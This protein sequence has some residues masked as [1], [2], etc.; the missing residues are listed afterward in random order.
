[1]PNQPGDKSDA[2]VRSLG[3]ELASWRDRRGVTQ[4]ELSAMTGISD[5]TIKRIEAQGP[6]SAGDTWKIAEA[7]GVSLEEIVRRANEALKIGE[8]SDEGYEEREGDQVV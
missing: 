6:K 2:F 1:M 8:G 5:S 7:L 3:K 4:V